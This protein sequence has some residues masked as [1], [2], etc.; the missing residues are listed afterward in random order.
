[1]ALRLKR[2]SDS[3]VFKC[4]L[5][6]PFEHY[7]IGIQRCINKNFIVGLLAE[8]VE[9]NHQQKPIKFSLMSQWHLDKR[10]IRVNTLV[11][12]QNE[13]GIALTHQIRHFPLVLQTF[14]LYCWTAHKCKWGVGL[15]ILI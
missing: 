15:Q 9:D 3:I 5:Y 8:K 2:S 4:D 13:L 10:G 14:G 1:M 12:T 6:H 7:L 11:N